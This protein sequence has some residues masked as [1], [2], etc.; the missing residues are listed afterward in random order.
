MEDLLTLAAARGLPVVWR[1]LGG[2]NGEYRSSGLIVLD[3]RRPAQTQRVTLAHELGHAHYGHRWSDDP[4]VRERQEAAAD[5]YAANLLITPAAYAAAER[6]TGC[7]A[8]ALARELAVT[9]RL[10]E[11]WREQRPAQRRAA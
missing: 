11:M 6:L 9:A 1:D 3:P 2:R 4:R 8:G 10:V 5:R 7:H